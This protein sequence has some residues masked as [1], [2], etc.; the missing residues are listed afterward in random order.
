MPPVGAR[1]TITLNVEAN[2][3]QE[4]KGRDAM[5]T[6]ADI[7]RLYAGILGDVPYDAMTRGDGGGRCCRAGTRPVTSR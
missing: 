2:K 1:N 5:G 4:S 3:R 6:A 7:V